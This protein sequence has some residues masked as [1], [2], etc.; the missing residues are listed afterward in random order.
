MPRLDLPDDGIR[1]AA[2]VRARAFAAFERRRATYL[3]LAA[4]PPAE[5]ERPPVKTS[6]SSRPICAEVARQL[7]VPSDWLKKGAESRGMPMTAYRQLAMALICRLT[8]LNLTTIARLFDVNDHSTVIHAKRTMAPVL[9]ATGLTEADSV[10][11]WIEACLPLLFVHV[12]EHRAKNRAHGVTMLGTDGKF[13]GQDWTTTS[14]PE[15]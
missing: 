3:K 10:P 4:A 6:P 1:T 9:D 13:A 7:G 14:P 5:P 12:A 11:V 8:K 15:P 2:D